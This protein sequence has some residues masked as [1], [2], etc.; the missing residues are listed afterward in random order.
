[1]P[2]IMALLQVFK[3]LLNG[4][5]L[6]TEDITAPY[7]VSWNT[8]TVVNGVYTLTARARDAAEIMQH[9]L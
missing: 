2:V 8:T 4:V 9:P 6:G 1:M 3:F 7:T 5:N